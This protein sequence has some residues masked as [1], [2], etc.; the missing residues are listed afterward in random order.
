MKE[1]WILIN[2]WDNYAVSNTGKV[3]NVRTGKEIKQVENRAGY[4]IVGLCQNK[5]RPVL[6]F[7]D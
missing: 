5:K 1:I 2:N 4:L 7:I 6:E 3:K